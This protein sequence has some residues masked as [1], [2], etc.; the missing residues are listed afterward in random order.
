VL[1]LGRVAFR[2]ADEPVALVLAQDVGRLEA[3]R[4]P[5]RDL[6]EERGEVTRREPVGEQIDEYGRSLGADVVVNYVSRE[7]EAGKVVEEIRRSRDELDAIT[8]RLT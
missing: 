8:R 1:G 5:P 2:R 6:Q 4:T 7:E 3:R